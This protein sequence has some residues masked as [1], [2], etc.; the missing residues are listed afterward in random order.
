MSTLGRY[1]AMCVDYYKYSLKSRKSLMKAGAYYIV[2]D[3]LKNSENIF[4]KI[5]RNDLIVGIGIGSLNIMLHNMEQ[6]YFT[7]KEMEEMKDNALKIL[8]SRKTEV[9]ITQGSYNF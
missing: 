4:K 6:Q 1:C 5:N 8:N 7:K 3:T 2:K 9:Y